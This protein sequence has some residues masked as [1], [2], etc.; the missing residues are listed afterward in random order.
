[1][2][3]FD[4]NK[5]D[6]TKFWNLSE[7]TVDQNVC[8]SDIEKL[9]YLKNRFTGDAKQAISGIPLSKENN[10][11]VETLL[12]ERF[13]DVQL[14]LHNHMELINLPAGR[15]TPKGLRLMY[16]HMEKH[17]GCLEALNPNLYHEIFIPVITTKLPKEVLFQLAL[18]KGSENKWTVNMLREMFND[19]I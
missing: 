3:L 8:L 2:P 12:R 16:D 19:C 18:Q 6:W 1:M 14:V 7:V 5:M 4:G 15:N 9:C 10:T 11:V 13:E 17:F